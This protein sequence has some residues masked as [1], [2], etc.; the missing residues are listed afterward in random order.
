M[1]HV[2]QLVNHDDDGSTSAETYLRGERI[3]Q[4]ATSCGAEAIHPGYGF[5]AESADF[6]R[7]CTDAGV[8][9]VGPSPDVLRAMGDKIEAK[10][11]M[12]KA[13]VP[14]VGLM[15]DPPDAGGADDD[16]EQ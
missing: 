7:Q 4:L 15:T 2:G 11:I 8:V 1:N 12:Q 14:E 9:F 13:G 3:I 10:A 6:A 5:L 16:G